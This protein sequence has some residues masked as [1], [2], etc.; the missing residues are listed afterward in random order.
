MARYRYA[1]LQEQIVRNDCAGA[2]ICS[3]ANLRYATG[4]KYAQVQNMHSPFRSVFVPAQGKAVFYDWPMYTFGQQPDFIGEYRDSF[5]TSHF[6]S[7]SS[8][9]EQTRLWAA[10]LAELVKGLGSGSECLAIDICEPELVVHLTRAGIDIVNAEKLVERAAAIKSDDEIVCMARAISVAEAGLA[11]IREELRP[12]ISEQELW[13]HLAHENARHGGEW[14][15]YC[16]LASGERTNPWGRECGDKIIQTGELVG[17]DTGMVG[18]HGYCADV[19]RTFFCG[20]G[21]P[22]T[23]QKHLYRTAVDNLAFNIDL[24][25]AGMTFREFAD[26]SWP[27]PDEFWARRYNSIAHGVGMGNEWPLIPFA[28]DAIGH[29]DDDTVFVENMVLAI[30]SCIGRE[31]GVE[32]V[33]LEDMVVVKNGKCHLLSTF[34]FETDLLS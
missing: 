28:A 31:D 14:F 33:K 2:L 15:N 6:I 30:E 32:C 3:S 12:G 29:E 26:R 21:T 22:T 9:G 25:R 13:S 18:P 1:R 11:R 5:A 20:P 16:I 17:V 7:G 23:E 4:T 34:P 27:V 8:Y 19:S 24:I 10:D